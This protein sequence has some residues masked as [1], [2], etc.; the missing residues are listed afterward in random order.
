MWFRAPLE[1]GVTK[2]NE[3]KRNSP[4]FIPTLLVTGIGGPTP[5]AIVR[6]LKQ[7]GRFGPYRVIGVD[8]NPFAL[9]LYESAFID[10]AYLV[11]HAK[12][13]SYWKEIERI[14]RA[15][16]IT[17]AVIQPDIEVASWSERIEQEKAPCLAF[18]PPYELVKV[19]L[20]KWEITR[21]LHET[22]L[23]PHTV[24]VDL[25][26][27][28]SEVVID[29]LGLPFWV[30]GVAGSSGLGAL[31]IENRDDLKCWI[32]IQPQIRQFIASE[33]LPG[34]NFGC[35]CIFWKGEL[36]RAACLERVQY[37][38]SRVAPSGITGNA[39]FGRLVNSPELVALASQAVGHVCRKTVTKPHGVL[40][41]DFKEDAGGVP[42]VTE[43][44]VRHVAT[45]SALAAGGANLA[46]DTVQ[47]ALGHL[48]RV[49]RDGSFVFK[50]GLVFLRDVDG[51]PIV[52]SE[53]NLLK[54]K[55][56]WPGLISGLSIK[57]RLEN[58]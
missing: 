27:S 25:T 28:E 53:E 42:K 40:T 9:G 49:P 33:Y 6:S 21:A 7:H 4:V 36:L 20:N 32:R 10:K 3:Q 57:S 52:M 31:K 35:V 18:L 19:L 37:L 41:V 8:C 2:I 17:V 30:R 55:P 43:I 58:G 34:R 26:D 46:E 1:L 39:S 16:N 45:T 51:A 50:E 11:P 38:M 29:S 24:R 54:S 22:G 5:R 15:E 56:Y 13:A 44:N 47:L 12:E 48:E 23:A 14:V